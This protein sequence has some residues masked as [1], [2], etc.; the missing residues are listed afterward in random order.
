M[1]IRRIRKKMKP[2]IAVFVVA[3]AFTIVASFGFSLYSSYQR[4]K[5][6]TAFVLNGERVALSQVYNNVE[7]EVAKY[8]NAYNGA[9]DEE[10]LRIYAMN[11]F[12][13]SIF[14]VEAGEKLKIKVSDEEIDEQLARYKSSYGDE[15]TFRA[16]LRARGLNIGSVK[17]GIEA[18]LI[19]VK[20]IDKLKEDVKISDDAIEYDYAKNR[21]GLYSG[22]SLDEVKEKIRVKLNNI[23]KEKN[24]RKWAKAKFDNAKFEEIKDDVKKYMPGKVKV[25]NFEFSNSE[26]AM[27]ILTMQM[28]Y[29]QKDPELVKTLLNSMM[30]TDFNLA[31]EALKAGI[32][33]DKSLETTDYIMELGENYRKSLLKDV[34]PTDAELQK[35]FNDNKKHYNLPETAS[36]NLIKMKIEPSKEDE[37][38]V[39]QQ[40]KDL[41]EILKKDITKFDELAKEHSLDKTSDL[42]YFGKGNMVKP[43]EDAVFGAKEKGLLLEPVKTQYGYHIVNVTDIKDEKVRAS[44]ILLAVKPSKETEDKVLENSKKIVNDLTVKNISVENAAKDN[45]DLKQLKFEN[46]VKDSYI[47]GLG[48]DKTLEN[49]I[50]NSKINEF[51]NI[52]ADSG[53]YI[54]QLLK[55]R[56]KKEAKFEE[57]KESLVLDY[58]L[59][60]AAD[61]ITKVKLSSIK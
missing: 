3:F 21:L 54:Y 44:H 5:A 49:A 60:I 59:K 56:D 41:I 48:V 1:A 11:K 42:G 10:Q 43:F 36:F 34:K 55:R 32:T 9:L 50:F 61:K 53:I 33:A 31:N 45:N 2:I 17:R 19:R 15:R 39:I 16:S 18:D 12:L 30:K 13:L 6:N 4:K 29:K 28:Q 58:Q 35:F 23:E 47:P 40:A 14:I 46:I 57:V 22:K 52:K 26:Y 27:R 20:T 8:N 7:Q 24:F 51:K 37:K 38:V 25:D